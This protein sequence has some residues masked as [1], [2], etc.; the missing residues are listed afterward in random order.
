MKREKKP[1]CSYCKG[2]AESFKDSN[3]IIGCNLES[4]AG[5]LRWRGNEEEAKQ[6]DEI[7]SRIK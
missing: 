2:Y 4:I 3:H 5:V 7:A 1:E 6:L